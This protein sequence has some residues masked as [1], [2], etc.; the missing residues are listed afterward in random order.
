MF[1]SAKGLVEFILI[2]GK[3]VYHAFDEMSLLRSGEIPQC[4]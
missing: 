4:R 2:G 1:F 3:G